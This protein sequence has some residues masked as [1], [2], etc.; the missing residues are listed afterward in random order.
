MTNHPVPLIE[1]RIDIV[2]KEII[3]L[4]QLANDIYFAEERTAEDTDELIELE[5][6][7][8]IARSE[9]A[10]LSGDVLPRAKRGLP[11]TIKTRNWN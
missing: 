6:E 7:L 9:L 4:T 8:A 5:T 10:E 1:D 2:V 3:R 11:V